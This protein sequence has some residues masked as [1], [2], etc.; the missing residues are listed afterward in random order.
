MTSATY[1]CYG[2]NAFL[3]PNNPCIYP[4]IAVN[5]TSIVINKVNRRHFLL[6]TYYDTYTQL[7]CKLEDAHIVCI[8][9]IK[10]DTLGFG[11]CTTLD[12]MDHT[13][14]SY[15]IADS[16]QLDDDLEKIKAP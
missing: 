10:H 2:T 9:T 7:T 11:L 6:G 1:A 16:N 13:R 8:D 14:H 4:A 15:I 3:S 12:N 5:A